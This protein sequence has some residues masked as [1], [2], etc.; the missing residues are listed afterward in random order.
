M[1]ES[2]THLRSP[3]DESVL[4]ELCGLVWLVV[5]FATVFASHLP[6]RV[7]AIIFVDER[8]MHVRLEH[9]LGLLSDV[10]GD[11]LAGVFVSTKGGRRS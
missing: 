4:R 10:A 3:G 11:V 8:V 7:Y 1:S 5:V 6:A 2:L 9:S